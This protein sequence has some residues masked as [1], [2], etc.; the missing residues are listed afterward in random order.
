MCVLPDDGKRSYDFVGFLGPTA[1]GCKAD[2]LSIQT[3]GFSLGSCPNGAR[4]L[5]EPIL[6]GRTVWQ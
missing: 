3:V 4:R 1:V 5:F 6:R 2:W